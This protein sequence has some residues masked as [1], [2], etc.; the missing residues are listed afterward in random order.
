ML[1]VLYFVMRCRVTDSYDGFV[2]YGEDII[3][4]DEDIVATEALVFMLVGLGSSWKYPIGY[5]LTY[6]INASNLHAVFVK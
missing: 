2:N 3:A 1:T 4:F 5:V 6:K